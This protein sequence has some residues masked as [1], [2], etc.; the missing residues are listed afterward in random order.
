MSHTRSP[1]SVATVLG[2]FLALGVPAIIL[3]TGLLHPILAS[4]FGSDSSVQAVLAKEAV[5]WTLT[6]LVLIV[7]TLGERQPLSAIGFKR[8][9]FLSILFGIAGFA[10]V[11]IAQPVGLFLLKLIGG[12]FPTQKVS[13]LTSL[14]VWLLALILVRAS[15]CEE[16]LFR[17]YSI[18]RLTALSGSRILGTIIPA[19]IF[20]A[21]HIGTFGIRYVAFLIPVTT[22]L[23]AVYLIRRDIWANIVTHFLVDGLSLVVTLNAQRSG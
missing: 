21:G 23:T 7:L 5:F 13:K 8:I 12:S 17:G 1:T 16:I 20:M 22:I 4:Q 14:P 6:A 9:G 10:L 18:E 15:I 19:L 2:L 11:M 3:P